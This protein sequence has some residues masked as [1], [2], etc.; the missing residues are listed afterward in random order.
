MADALRSKESAGFGNWEDTKRRM[1]WTRDVMIPKIEKIDPWSAD[2]MQSCSS[3]VYVCECAA[4]QAKHFAGTQRCRKRFCLVCAHHRSMSYVAKML[5]RIMPLVESGCDMHMLTMTIRDQEDLADQI[6]K[7]K[8]AWRKIQHDD[9]TIRRKFKE[10]FIGGFRSFEVKIGR[11]SGLWH[12]HMHA[13]VLTPP[14][15]FEKDYEWLMPAWKKHTGGNGSIEIHKVKKR[16]GQNWGILKAII[17]TVKYVTS[18]DKMTTSIPD[19][20]F[21]EMYLFMKGFRAFNS[22]GVLRG[23]VKEAEE[24]DAKNFDEKKLADFVCRLCG[25]REAEFRVLWAEALKNSILLDL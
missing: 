4:C 1:Q 21:A 16:Q 20:R 8:D 9:K 3:V 7:L 15:K 25:V 23:V 2:V 14:G 18:P 11:N 17:E 6:G 22:W 24:V 5:E 10:R 12:A 13:I 19:D